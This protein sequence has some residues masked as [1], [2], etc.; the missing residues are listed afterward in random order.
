ML[1]SK[2]GSDGKR[3]LW[4]RG[5]DGTPFLPISQMSGETCLTSNITIHGMG[6]NICKWSSWEGINIQN[7]QIVHEAQYQKDNAIKKWV[8]DLNTR[9]SKE[10][11]QMAK[12]HMKKCLTSLIIREIKIK[13]TTRTSLVMRWIR[14]YLP[15]KFDSWSGK[16]YMPCSNEI[17]EP[18]PLSLSAAMTEACAL[19]VCALQQATTR[20]LCTTTGA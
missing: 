14:I 2:F 4:I 13:P 7:I 19:G 6:E 15:C 9:F 5:I 10:N 8:E 20:S 17:H 1:T 18:Q 11:I 16:V 3:P 12:R